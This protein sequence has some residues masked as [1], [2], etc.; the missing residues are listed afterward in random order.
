[1][2]RTVILIAGEDAY[3]EEAHIPH[4]VVSESYGKGICAAGGIRVLALDFR[5]I[6]E[7]VELTDGLLLTQ[8]P[9]I[10]PVR[11]G[12]FFESSKELKGFVASR[13]SMDFMLCKAFLDAGKP[14]MGIGRGAK[15]IQLVASE[16]Q[17]WLTVGV[18]CDKEKLETAE[19]YRKFMDL[20]VKEGEK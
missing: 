14:V 16:E 13:D 17:K 20:C 4:F 12:Q 7:Y 9:V 15:V 18:R 1:M 10:H 11:Y 5:T 2:K 3:D 8:G 6:K 19:Y